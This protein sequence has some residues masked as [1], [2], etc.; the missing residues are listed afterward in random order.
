MRLLG[1]VA[2]GS[3]VHHVVSFV[4]LGKRLR[5][6]RLD[7][8]DGPHL[9]VRQRQKERIELE[10]L[11]VVVVHRA[12]VD[13][14][15]KDH[16]PLHGRVDEQRVGQV[17]GVAGDHGRRVV[18]RAHNVGEAPEAASQ[19]PVH[20][21]HG[22][23]A[24]G[25]VLVDGAR[26]AREQQVQV[27]LGAVKEHVPEVLRWRILGHLDRD[28]GHHAEVQRDLAHILARALTRTPHVHVARHA[29]ETRVRRVELAPARAEE[30]HVADATP[31]GGGQVA[32][33]AV[34][35]VRHACSER[36]VR[37]SWG[38]TLVKLQR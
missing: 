12:L 31:A 30:A 29:R 38:C 13:G 23:H 36:Q 19:A 25:G 14:P 18:A 7:A 5:P 33:L 20:I 22:C 10:H 3:V 24:K 35:R 8:L 34:V 15:H 28:G 17:G 4:F 6:Q 9:V 1:H 16:G 2:L 32:R 37:H 11:D 21:Q 27:V 26:R